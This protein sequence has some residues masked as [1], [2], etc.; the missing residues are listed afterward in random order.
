RDLLCLH[1][2]FDNA[3]RFR[4]QDT[5]V[6]LDKFNL[7]KNPIKEFLRLLDI[8][9]S[10]EKRVEV[11]DTWHLTKLMFEFLKYDKEIREILKNAFLRLNL[12]KC[13]IN[14]YDMPYCLGRKD[15][16]FNIKK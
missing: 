4:F 5:F 9:S 13:K 7:A 8:M 10:K 15:Y 11:K 6:E 2:E 1:F 3:Y 14:E 12:E 16:N